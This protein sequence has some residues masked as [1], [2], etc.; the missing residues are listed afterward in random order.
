MH[1]PKRSLELFYID[2]KPDGMLAAEI[3]DWTGHVLAVPRLRLAEAFRREEMRRTGVYILLGEKEEGP[4]AYIGEAEELG[5]RL[6]Q[7]V[8]GKEWWEKALLITTSNNQLNK[9][10]G[11]YLEAR[12]I[13]LA[14]KTGH[15]RLKNNTAPPVPYLR[16]VEQ[17]NMEGFLENLLMIF[18]ALRV[19][20]FIEHTR[21]ALQLQNNVLQEQE[22]TH[23]GE[24]TLY[25]ELYYSKYDIC[26]SA[27]LRDGEFIVEAGSE[28]YPEW[29]GASSHFIGVREELLK[30]GIL[31]R[32]KEKLVFVKNYVCWSAASA[33]S[34]IIG[35]SSGSALWKVKG[36]KTSFRDLERKWQEV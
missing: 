24:E 31:V 26:A 15:T 29:Q 25:F 20:M 8:S 5:M 4:C 2:G 30:N 18:P 12:L 16:E 11:R 19:D 32:Q 3:F 33:A 10:H 17:A 13:G 22:D 9:A 21:P 1:A 6:K 7:H 27:V 23:T 36:E 34:L 28:A 35:R 14:R